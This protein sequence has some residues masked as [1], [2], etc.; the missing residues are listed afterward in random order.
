[1]TGL[2]LQDRAVIVTG[3]GN[4]IGRATALLCAAHGAPV[5]VVDRDGPSA[6]RVAAELDASGAAA[7]AIEADVSDETA[8]D[9]VVRRATAELGPLYGI[10]NNAG[11][12]VTKPLA[13][14]TVA[15]WEKV[16]AVNARGAFLGCRAAV[17][18]FLSTDTAGAIVNI[19]SISATV[20]LAGQPA[21]CASKGA[22]LQ[23]SRQI[24]VDYSRHGIRCNVVSPGSVTTAVLDDYLSG[25]DKPDA[26][27]EDII[28]AHPIGRLAQ[29]AEIAAAVYFALSPEASFLTGANIAADGGYTA[30]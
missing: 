15:E 1:M 12:I 13:E 27:R 28:A 20:G 23:L 17:R 21:Y 18:E 26:A 10:V 3:A 6:K 5:A 25:Q 22:V 11:L 2:T 7:I 8:V 29:P 9:N 4:G 16:M 19:G 30:Q 24:A 14:T